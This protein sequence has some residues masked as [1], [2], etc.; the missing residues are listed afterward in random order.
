MIDGL[1]ESFPRLL[2]QNI[3]GLLDQAEPTPLKAYQLYKACE[4][5]DLWRGSFAEFSRRLEDYYSR[6]RWRR[7]KAGFDIHLERPMPQA[8]FGAFHLT[9]RTAR[10]REAAVENL[11]SWAHHLMRVGSKMKSAVIS[12]EVLGRVFHRLIRPLPHEK[13]EDL[14]L[15]DF[16]GVWRRTVFQSFGHRFD[17]D[18][19]FLSTELRWL[20]EKF[21]ATEQAQRDRVPVLIELTQT[22][23]DWIAAIRAAVAINRPAPEFPLRRGPQKE[24]LRQLERV[25]RLYTLSLSSDSPE[26]LKNKANIRATISYHLKQL[27]DSSR[28]KA[29]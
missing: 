6:P 19:E 15:S 7:S 16:L 12:K 28:N 14:N 21:R 24:P 29:A 17:E 25:A 27:E 3:D 13:D 8:T 1:W 18:L 11:T 10:V 20:D 4:R 26:L 22:E 2:E 23:I 5:E 9:F